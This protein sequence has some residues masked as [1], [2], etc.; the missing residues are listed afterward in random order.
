MPDL[1]KALRLSDSRRDAEKF[2][3][4]LLAAEHAVD[5]IDVLQKKRHIDIDDMLR[6][7]LPNLADA[8]GASQAFVL[9]FRGSTEKAEKK[10]FELTAAYPEMQIYGQ[11]LGAPDSFVS[12]VLDGKSRIVEDLEGDVE[13]SIPGLELFEA[14]T[15]ILVRMEIGTQKRIVGV[16][17][18]LGTPHSRFLAADRQT[19][20]LLIKL[21][22]LGFQIGERRRRELENIQTITSAIN[23]ET[24]LNELLTIIA[25]GASDIFDTPTVSLMLWDEKK[26]Y[27]SIAKGRGLSGE[28]I[29]RQRL[30]SATIYNIITGENF[31]PA[32]IRDLRKT[33]IGISHLVKKEGLKSALNAPLMTS[34]NL[35]GFLTIY[36][37]NG[38]REFTENEIELAEIFANH[39][40]IAIQ[41]AQRRQHELEGL[42][43][44]SE[45]LKATLDEKDLLVLI[46]K[47]VAEFFSVPAASVL[48]WDASKTHLVVRSSQGISD[49]FIDCQ[50]IERQMSSRFATT[51]GVRREPFVTAN[52]R[53]ISGGRRDL[54][55]NEGIQ[56]ALIAPLTIPHAK[57]MMGFLVLYNKTA[58]RHFSDDEIKM[59]NVI[60]DQA[61]VAIQTTQLHHLNRQRG[62]QLDALNQI[63]LNITS[64]LSIEDL[65][66]AIIKNAT[67]LLGAEGGVVYR[68]NEKE[69]AI[70]PVAA[71][72]QYDLSEIK[73][74]KNKGVIRKITTTKQ[75]FA[76]AN[77][78]RWAERQK[79]L[80]DYRLT[81]VAGAP[82]LTGER[83]T[84]IIVVHDSREGR[85]FGARELD[86]LQS[87]ANHAAVAIENAEAWLVEHQTK[88][89]FHRLIS[90]ATDG[91]I[92]VDA[93]GTITIYNEGA[94]QLC[95]YTADEVKEMKVWHLYGSLKTAQD[96]NRE[97]FKHTKLE[98]YETQ[99]HSKDGHEIP[100]MLSASLLKDE[101]GNH[102]G[103]VGFF[104]DLR[105]IRKTF[106]AINSITSSR[107]LN[108][109][110]RALAKGMVDNL[111]I[112]FCY[113]LMINEGGQYLKTEAICESDRSQSSRSPLGLGAILG[114][115]DFS[116]MNQVIKSPISYTF[117]R[118]E[119]INDIEIVSD[120]QKQLN[121]KEKLESIAVIPILGEHGVLG[122]CILGES[123]GRERHRFTEEQLSTADLLVRNAASFIDRLQLR[124]REGLLRASKEITSLRDLSSILQAITD[125][126]RDALTCDLV[127]LYTYDEAAEIL[128]FP[129]TISGDLHHPDDIRALGRTSKKSVIWKAL[130]KGHAYYADDTQHDKWMNIKDSERPEGII[131]FINREKITSSAAI[132]L[133]IR[134]E[135]VGVLF[136][137]YRTPH[138][139]IEQEKS[140]IE[141]FAKQA[142]LAINNTRLFELSVTTAKYFHALFDAGKALL[143][144]GFSDRLSL[145]KKILQEAVDSVAGTSNE[146][147][148]TGT[149]QIMDQNTSELVFEWA[150]PDEKL[151]QIID[152]LGQR[153]SIGAEKG[154]TVQAAV[155]RELQWVPNVQQNSHYLS[156]KDDTKS[157]VAVPLL[158][159]QRVL[160]VLD[161]ESD[162]ENAFS[163]NDAL[164]L[165]AL[166][167]IAVLV[168]KNVDQ[169]KEMERTKDYLLTS[170]AVAWLGLFGADL[171]HTIHQK[172]FSFDNY[173][174]AIRSWLKRLNPAPD[175]I[176]DIFRALDGIEAASNSIRAV[177]FTTQLPV[178]MPS[179][180]NMKTAIDNEL[181]NIVE[182]LC[183]GRPDIDLILDLNCDGLQTRIAPQGLRVALEKLV[184]N[185]LKAMSEQGTLMVR[186]ERSGDL[187]NIMIKD[188]GKGIPETALPYFLRGMVPRNDPKESTGTGVLIARF[189]ALS[190]GG[191]LILVSTSK[192]GTELQMMLPVAT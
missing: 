87:F 167:D 108:E 94:E 106:Y 131:P 47:K 61:A 77:Y 26:E 171:Q 100:I 90:S 135:K 177:Q 169:Y 144:Y 189:V 24:N 101:S 78:Y 45:A 15:A 95:G 25:R 148:I 86:L 159:G 75:P 44:T 3:R 32:I 64:K 11:N 41:N 72:G 111:G 186:S 162:K 17:N 31:R 40:A 19:F 66:Q 128:N 134:N 42:L 129:P 137:N 53:F 164:A 175:D 81:G 156:Y 121:R 50:D 152:K 59:A 49:G 30:P 136:V 149:I 48:L 155:T 125:S 23:A 74:N 4:L 58:R 126:V 174:N 154:I 55:E 79:S 9:A 36:A 76:R 13:K 14:T 166:A 113:V 120:V 20:N 122:A 10:W 191:D 43:A 140:D 102:K 2:H 116:L 172:S 91:I 99:I 170:Q 1:Q 133:L 67:M 179:V 165:Q 190:H 192:M 115:S 138:H 93:E 117:H 103:S 88:E 109:G 39:A 63:A 46:T 34:R 185:S 119:R 181:Q 161:V 60:A 52:H 150:Y 62:E 5:E 73:V 187:I 147:G 98:N 112:T 160:G 168:L 27:L 6:R 104:K 180:V 157:E 56:D 83:L 142:A 123:R 130:E 12:V 124:L 38:S 176:E 118:G 28:Y 163:K 84:G 139:F 68:W 65:L 71:Y 85:N 146:K 107:D 114:L 8:L 183:S 35:I 80:D 110:L 173:V 82:I 184:N 158:D 97:L 188:T 151:P 127:T 153:L 178:E 69:D 22:V 96:I 89:F 141:I 29:L 70:L 92:A 7:L 16:C 105:P 132:P 54:M 51:S 18:N 143:A 145:L 57:E 21:V 182:N 37:K 33:P